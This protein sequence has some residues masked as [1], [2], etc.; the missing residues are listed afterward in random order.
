MSGLTIREMNAD[1]V[2]RFRALYRDVWGYNRPLAY[3]TWRLFDTPH[4]VCPTAVAMDGERFAALYTVWPI[5]LNLG[6]QPVLGAQ[7]MDTMTHPDHQGKGLFVRTALACYDIAAARGIKAMYGLPNPHSYPGFV[8]R[9]NW[10]HTGDVWHYVRPLKMSR[11]AR[12][13]APMKPMVDLGTKM[14][15]TGR[16]GG[17]VVTEGTPP[18]DDVAA[19]AAMA[20]EKDT[21]RIDR[22]QTWFDWRYANG[23]LNGYRWTAARDANGRL[24]AVAVWGMRDETWGDVADRR[25]HLVELFGETPAAK[26]AAL[27]AA[28]T[29]ARSAH[30]ILMETL[31]SIPPTER[32]L[33]RA[34]FFRHRKAPLI[35]RK[36]TAENLP[37]N[38]HDHHAWRIMGGD[39]DTF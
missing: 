30:A 8:R 1:D 21:C 29:Q 24:A 14:L 11:H 5:M 34:G 25:A 32:V 28:L 17:F 39:V 4:G 15:P 27:A 19:L 7:S 3:D 16:A 18:L 35:A 2:D 31:C 20:M 10:D 13:P 6:G 26:S 12:V 38:I 37:A 22:S 36:T 23:A 33:R 9:L